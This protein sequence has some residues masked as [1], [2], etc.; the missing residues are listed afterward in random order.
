MTV[1]T[2]LAVSAFAQAPSFD[3]ASIKPSSPQE[4]Q[5]GI[6]G[7]KTG[8]GRITAT[9]VTL[10][11]CIF[12]SY[13]IGP[14]QIIGGPPWLDSDRFHIEGKAA[15]PT[16]D[17][18]VLDAMTRTLLADRFHLQAHRETR[19]MTAL[20]LEVTKQGAKLDPS[21]GGGSSTDASHGSLKIRNETMDDFAERL[22]RV[23]DMPVVNR[24]GLLGRFNL[25]LV[26]TPDD[27]H[28]KPDGPPSLYTAIQ[29]Q[30]GLRLTSR[31]TQVQV[32]VIDHAEKPDEN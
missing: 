11:R 32:L 27:D 12:G 9:N 23:T 14:H 13:H 28:A 16:D 25:K 21:D 19:T 6:S 24:T 4:I 26:W 20:V 8:H 22:A 18:T 31:R 2:L 3:V 5:A 1:L 10:K 7:I 29:E 30:L 17:D 15:E